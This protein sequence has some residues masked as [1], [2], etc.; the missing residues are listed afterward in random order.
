[1]NKERHAILYN[2]EQLGPYPMEK[3]K[4]VDEPTTRYVGEVKPRGRHESA[5]MKAARGEFGA[6]VQEKMVGSFDREPLFES[7][8]RI[9][10]HLNMVPELEPAPD[11]APWTDE[12][13]VTTRH[14]KK[15]AY[16]LGVDMV[17]ICEVPKSALYT[18]QMDGTP[19]EEVTLKYAIVII[20]GKKL[21]T[22]NATYG[23]EWIDDP[24]SLQCYQRLSLIS[25]DIAAYIRLLGWPARASVVES[26]Y[27]TLMPELIIRSGLGE[28]SRLG[29]ALNP[30]L[31][32]AIKGACVLTDLPLIPDKPI[33]FGLQEYCS[34]CTICAEQC[35]S[36]AI[37]KGEKT[38]HNGYE[39]WLLNSK[40]CLIKSI[41]NDHGKV[42]GRCV[43]VCPWTRPDSRPED[44]KDWDGDI[45][46]LHDSVNRQA[47]WLKEHNYVHPDENSKKWWLPLERQDGKLAEG[48]EFNYNLHYKKMERLKAKKAT[49][50]E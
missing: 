47:Q 41:S 44:F 7:L 21:D 3:L 49:F 22:L 30:F 29:I 34:K 38:V 8:A 31:G 2:D 25:E 5:P 48:K 20:V 43:K 26:K 19:I 28:G 18:H 15:L 27:L 33:D 9:A 45:K 10:D 12:P 36:G 16:F 37:A 42:C 11:K 13:N 17:G 14:I 1:M 32:A 50:P 39:T 35:L 24:I 6:K 40:A 4:R 23:D 46:F